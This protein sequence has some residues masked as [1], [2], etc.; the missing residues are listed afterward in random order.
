MKTPKVELI[1]DGNG[2]PHVVTWP[3][4]TGWVVRELKLGA[5]VPDRQSALKFAQ[6][7]CTKSNTAHQDASD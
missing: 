7:I 4:G 1:R 2:N 5:W 6:D 3:S